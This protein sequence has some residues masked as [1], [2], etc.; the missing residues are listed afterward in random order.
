MTLREA[1]KNRHSVRKY[2]PGPIPAECREELENC[3]QECNEESGLHL[4]VI[5][6][7]P[8]CFDTLFTKYGMFENV[9][10]YIAIVGD[11]SLKDLACIVPECSCSSRGDGNSPLLL[12]H[13]PVHRGGAVMDLPD[14]V[15][16]PCV[17]QDA[18]RRGGLSG[19]DVRHDTDITCEV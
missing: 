3:I 14:L 13:H 2:L 11:K 12:L 4:Q 18:L 10:N 6:D 7:E 8:G 19:I 1:I 15:R 9:E 5:Y 17:E 16:L